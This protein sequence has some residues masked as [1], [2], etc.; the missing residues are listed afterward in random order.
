MTRR[1]HRL[2][3]EDLRMLDA[4]DRFGSFRAAA[5]ELFVVTSSI[6]H[7]VQKLEAQLGLV[8]FD[9]SGRQIR[10]TSEGKLLLSKGRELLNR[11]EAFD[12]EVQLIATG[13]EATLTIAIDQA[14]RTE[15]LIPLLTEF[16]RDAP[17]TTLQLRREAVAGSWDAL[18]SG[19]ADL[20]IGAPADG[21]AGSPFECAKLC[22]REFTFVVASTHP[23]AGWQGEVPTDEIARHRAVLIGDTA[24]AIPHWPLSLLACRTRLMVPDGAT[25]L[26]AILAG[27]GC[28]FISRAL[29]EAFVRRGELVALNVAAEPPPRSSMLAW[30]SGESGRALRWWRERLLQPGV[31]EALVY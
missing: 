17:Q 31:G 1:R 21:P 7:A 20:I 29:A 14:M 11:A 22:E 24:Q 18:L 12:A 3:L 9:R 13:W 15:P 27:T 26:A 25:R 30:R 10:F 16:V 4:I 19:R 28:G 6:T 5:R 8:V 23:L 2:D